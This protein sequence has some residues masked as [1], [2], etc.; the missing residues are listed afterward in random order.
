MMEEILKIQG[1][2]FA[3]KFRYPHS[4]FNGPYIIQGYFELLSFHGGYG[5]SYSSPA[6]CPSNFEN[7]KEEL[8]QRIVTKMKEKFYRFRR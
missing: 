2:Q 4:T 8:F 6:R 1:Y 7:V 5:V 3:V